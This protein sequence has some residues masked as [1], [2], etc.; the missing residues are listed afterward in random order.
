M[1]SARVISAE[2]HEVSVPD[3]SLL[4]GTSEIQF[5]IKGEPCDATEPPQIVILS[6]ELSELVF[7]YARILVNGSSQFVHARRPILS[8]R[9]WPR[10]FGRHLAVDS[11]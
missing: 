7:V 11:E 3:P 8:G 4:H 5:S 6:T 9:H 2:A 10:K 1:L